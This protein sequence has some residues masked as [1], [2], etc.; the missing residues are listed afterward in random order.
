MLSRL[1]IQLSL[2][3]LQPNLTVTNTMQNIN[4]SPHNS[5]KTEYIQGTQLIQHT[6]TIRNSKLSKIAQES[7]QQLVQII[8]TTHQKA[9]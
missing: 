4:D 8:M 5:K 9:I 2:V 1:F 6:Q 7:N 3:S